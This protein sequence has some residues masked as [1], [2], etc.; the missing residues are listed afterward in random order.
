L[1]RLFLF[2]ISGIFPTIFGFSTILNSS[3]GRCMIN[4]NIVLVLLWLHEIR[5]HLIWTIWK[6]ICARGILFVST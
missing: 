4:K 2:L 6:F 1:L 3:C 5:S